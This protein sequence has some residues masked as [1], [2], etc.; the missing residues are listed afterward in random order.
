MATYEKIKGAVSLFSNSA[1]IP[2][3]YGV[4]AKLILERMV[5]HGLK[6]AMISNYGMEGRVDQITTPFGKVDHYPKGLALHSE[7]SAPL[8]ASRHEAKHPD[9][10]HVM[11]MLYDVWVYDKMQYDGEIWCWVPIDHVTMPPAVHKFLLRDNVH[12][13]AMAPHGQREMQKIGIDA[14]F[15]PHALDTS[16]FKPTK[17][18]DGVPARKYLGIPDDA[19]LVSIVAANKAN[20]FVHRKGF[21]E[22]LLAFATF[23]AKHPDSYLYLHTEPSRAFSG[24]DIKVLL[25]ACGLDES[26]VIIAN[27]DQLRVGY[28][29]KALAAIY[30]A[31]DVLLSATYGEG[32]GVPVIEA[33][34]CGTRVIGSNWAATQ[35]LVAESGWLV[36]GQP[37]WDNP[38][39]AFFQIP[40]IQAVAQSLEHAYQA[41]RGVDQTALEF[42]QQFAIEKVWR[43]GWM[44][45]LREIFPSV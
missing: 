17:N 15:V 33:Q 16:V 26:S 21:A 34:A 27:S 36:P 20:N 44:P 3:G 42:A 10:K 6:P 9:L 43:D 24:Y 2:T 39:S 28:P 19:F 13:I 45:I 11:L 31:S 1:G 14:S 5:R 4:Q 32:F 8:W 30:T 23:H 29:E 7:D 22:Q 35:D 41:E 37:F 18:I 25:Q 12:P 40:S 38:Q